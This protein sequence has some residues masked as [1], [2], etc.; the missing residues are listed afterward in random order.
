MQACCFPKGFLYVG[1][2]RYCC[3]D[4]FFWRNG[5]RACTQSLGMIDFGLCKLVVPPFE[6]LTTWR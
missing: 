4:N 6:K 5:G 3:W 1:V 2:D